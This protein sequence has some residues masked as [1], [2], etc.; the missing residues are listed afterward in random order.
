MN[1]VLFGPPGSGKGTQAKI[2]QE[3]R[4]LPQLS[5]GDMLRAAIAAG[6]ELGKKCKAI[7]DSGD[8]VPDEVVVGIIA[9]RYDQADCANGAVFDG[10]PRTIPQAEALDAMLKSRGRKIDLVIELKVDDAVL[11][12]RVEQRIKE[13]GGV[14]RADDTPETLKNR[15]TVYYKN[16]APLLEYYKRQ[17]KLA[18]VDGMAPIEEVTK[19]I[20]AIIDGTERK[21]CLGIG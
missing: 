13:S 7:M 16:T 17:G 2:L 3:R 18:T 15:L 14:A 4:G 10:F 9:E 8:L 20:A 5:T 1:L 19:A 12:Q 6:T 21:G 11:L